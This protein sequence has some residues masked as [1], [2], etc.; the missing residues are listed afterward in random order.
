[1]KEVCRSDEIR[2]AAKKHYS[3]VG[4]CVLQICNGTTNV[5][6]ERSREYYIGAE[7]K[8]AVCCV[9][10]VVYGYRDTETDYELGKLQLQG[11]KSAS[12]KAVGDSQRQLASYVAYVVASR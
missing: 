9:R 7:V 10:T 3:S 8:Q 12:G 5:F 4:T 1:M 6:L 11:R 2:R